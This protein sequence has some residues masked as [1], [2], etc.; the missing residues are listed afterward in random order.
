V[1]FPPSA[2]TLTAVLVV[3]TAVVRAEVSVAEL[4]TCVL[5]GVVTTAD[6]TFA[7]ASRPAELVMAAA[8]VLLELIDEAA[9]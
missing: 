5:D 6:I 4:M 9:L 8:L 2:C 3:V 7:E 1:A